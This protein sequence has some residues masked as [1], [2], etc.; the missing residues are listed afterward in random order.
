MFWDTYHHYYYLCKVPASGCLTVLIIAVQQ[1]GRKPWRS[2]SWQNLTSVYR[3][4]FLSKL[5]RR[6][7]RSIS[8]S[9]WCIICLFDCSVV[10]P[11][12]AQVLYST[13]LYSPPVLYTAGVSP[14]HLCDHSVSSGSQ[15]PSAPDSCS[16]LSVGQTTARS[17]LRRRSDA[18]QSQWGEAEFGGGGGGGDRPRD[19]VG[20]RQAGKSCWKG[21][22]SV[23]LN[24]TNITTVLSSD[25]YKFSLRMI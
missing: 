19:Q 5:N 8:V 15:S 13:V 25:L 10:W 20:H 17:E 12:L 9:L 6:G 14:N 7:D 2:V 16:T 23:L 21:K 22:A 1:S 18:A 11:P 4:H 24:N 3:N